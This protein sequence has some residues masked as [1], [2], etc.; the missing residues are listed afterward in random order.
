MFLSFFSYF[1]KVII[2]I[3]YSRSINSRSSR[4]SIVFKQLISG[5]INNL[6]ETSYTQYYHDSSW[7]SVILFFRVF[8]V[9]IYVVSPFL[10]HRFNFL[11][12]YISKIYTSFYI[13][14]QYVIYLFMLLIFLVLIYWHKTLIEINAVGLSNKFGLI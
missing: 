7:T 12:I 9:P 11:S 6:N 13:Y 10:K 8:W 3:R 2:T 5:K 14:T 1:L 4:C